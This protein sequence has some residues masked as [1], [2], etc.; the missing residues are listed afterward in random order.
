ME[1]NGETALG[2]C[3]GLARDCAANGIGFLVYM[4]VRA[5]YAYTGSFCMFLC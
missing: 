4:T 2:C 1:S 3:V 5:E